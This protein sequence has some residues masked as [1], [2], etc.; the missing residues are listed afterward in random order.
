MLRAGVASDR[1]RE[2]VLPE[3]TKRYWKIPPASESTNV[4]AFA[5][6]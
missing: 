2:L 1:G 5:D 6:S 3:E 4:V